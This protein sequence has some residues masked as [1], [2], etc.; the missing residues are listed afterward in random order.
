VQDQTSE[1]THIDT[2]I[3][4]SSLGEH[5]HKWIRLTKLTESIW[6]NAVSYTLYNEYDRK[7]YTASELLKMEQ[8]PEIIFL[9]NCANMSQ[10]EFEAEVKRV[11]PGATTQKL[12]L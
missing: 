4:P 10:E 7:I 2:R 5:S 8:R 11:L 1:A 9:K 12:K 3:T 6:E